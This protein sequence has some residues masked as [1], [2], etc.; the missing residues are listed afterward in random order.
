MEVSLDR[1]PNQIRKSITDT[2]EDV[3]SVHFGGCFSV[4]E[5]LTA[6]LEPIIIKQIPAKKFFENNT[7]ILSKGHCGLAYYSALSNCGVIS[8]N[9]LGAYCEDGGRF[10]GH[11]KRDTSIGVGWSTGSLGHGLSIAMGLAAAHANKDDDNMV[12]CVLGDGELHEG[13]NWEALLHLGM[14]PDINLRLIVDNNQMLSLGA[15]ASIRNLEPLE[16]KFRAFGLSP[17]SIDGNNLS[18]VR[19]AIK[20]EDSKSG[21]QVIIANTIKG[22]GISFMEGNSEWHAKRANAD[23]LRMIREELDS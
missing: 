9:E 4:A 14:F 1:F 22:K 2:A 5:I 12:T 19:R 3:G 23:T 7:L 16:Q 10:L 17:K 8:K 6:Y 13:S 20:P 15:T 21:I 11:I 18:E